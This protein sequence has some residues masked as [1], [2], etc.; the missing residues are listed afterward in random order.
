MIA[1]LYPLPQTDL[2]PINESRRA[3]ARPLPRI[4]PRPRGGPVLHAAPLADERVLSLNLTRGC[5][6]RCAFCCAR[7][8]S[9]YP[10]DDVLE[11]FTDSAGQLERELARLRQLPRAVYI[12]PATDPFPPFNAVQYETA[13]VVAVLAQHGIEAW[14]MT[15]G[16]IRPAIRGLLAEAADRVQVT[17]GLTTLARSL[18][19]VL[20]PLAAP[21]RL[22]L[23]QIAQLRRAGL[24]VRV[25]LE[26]L[27][28][29]VTDTRAQL[30]PLLEQLA[31]AGI[32]H[33]TAGY[34]FLRP[35]LEE[36]LL[37]QL[38][39]LGWDAPLRAAYAD[40]VMLSGGPLAAAR[41]LSKQ[42]RQRGYAALMT[43]A[44]EYGITV[45]I[46]SLT[47]PDFGSPR[48]AAPCS[49]QP[50]LPIFDR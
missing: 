39:P 21:T 44:A 15:R 7:A 18:R 14:L 13:R 50:L 26:P 17:F 35:G 25:A 47:N 32:H 46:S 3:M 20:E 28:P 48:L 36:Y 31:K 34:L 23:R 43:L 42:R 19:R 29:G 6:H 24:R 12:S 45:G 40:S 9:S 30:A 10:G 5:V 49:S 4:Q 22:R 1:T 41:Y 16:Y 27:L 8:Y 2:P 37:A 33:V 11:L 38:R